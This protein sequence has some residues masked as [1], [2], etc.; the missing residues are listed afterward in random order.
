[1][2]RSRSSC[3]GD[4]VVFRG[5]IRRG[6]CHKGDG[7]RV[8]VASRS[9]NETCG[10]R[11][12]TGS[13][14]SFG[15][16]RSRYRWCR[17]TNRCFRCFF[18]FR[19]GRFVDSS[20]WSTYRIS[21]SGS[22]VSRTSYSSNRPTGSGAIATY[23]GSGSSYSTRSRRAWISWAEVCYKRCGGFWRFLGSSGSGVSRWTTN[24]TRD[25]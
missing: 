17:R 4:S 12:T 19:G 13:T 1:M 6:G 8:F 22:T 11:V 10:G 18:I 3:S 15:S 20:G 21:R 23:S 9:S 2:R 14:C 7:T 25:S 24:T 16:R 5:W